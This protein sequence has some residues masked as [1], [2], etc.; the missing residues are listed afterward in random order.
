MLF[1]ASS[2]Q[3]KKVEERFRTSRASGSFSRD[4]RLQTC[5]FCKP[6]VPENPESKLS[7]GKSC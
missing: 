1:P 2:Y 3:L 5:I 6:D 4:K 7:L